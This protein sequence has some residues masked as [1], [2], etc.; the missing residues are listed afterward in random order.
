MTPSPHPLA[1]HELPIFISAPG[2]PDH[3]LIAMAIFLLLFVLAIGIIYL[4]LHALP[5]HIAHKSQKIQFEI[6]CVLGLLAMFTHIQAFW[7]AGLLLALI[8]IP[9]FGTPLNRIAG[10]LETLATTRHRRRHL[11][12]AVGG[13]ARADHRLLTHLTQPP[14]LTSPANKEVGSLDATVVAHSRD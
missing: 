12:G 11:V 4:R 10:A 13:E 5:D 8:D 1:S 6:V 7:I 2:E 14:Q 3:L 9:D